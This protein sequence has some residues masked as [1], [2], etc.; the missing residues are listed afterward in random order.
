M[1]W[2]TM[3]QE[4]R[5]SAD[6]AVRRIRDNEWVSL[7]H[8]AGVPQ[9]CVNA[10]I[11]NYK[12]FKNVSIYHMLVL[13]EAKYTEPEMEEA[14]RHVSNFI[15]ANTRSAIKEK[16]V[17]FLPAF[18][19]EIPRMIRERLIPIDV[20]IVQ[21][22]P[23]DEDGNCS[24]GIS[25]DYSKPSTEHARLVIGEINEQMPYIGGDNLIHLSKLDCIVEADYPLY[26]IA[27]PRITEVEEAIGRNCATLIEDGATLQLGIGAIP[28]A[29]LLFLKDKKNLGIHS[30]MF[31]DGV[32]ELVKN[33]VINGKAK[34][35][36]PNK[37]VATFLMGT[38]ALYD[39]VNHNPDVEMYPS[40][41][42]N[43]PRVIAQNDRMISINSCLSVDLAG[44]VSSESIG[45]QQI[46][47]TGGQ[48]DYVRGSNWSKGGKSIMAMPSTAKNGTTSRIVATLTEGTA[49]T[50][51]RN[52]VD[53]VV[54]EYG[55]ARLRGKSLRERAK[56][57]IKIAHPDFREELEAFYQQR[58]H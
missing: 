43:D 28:D 13:G 26:T 21:L 51:S 52:D 9:M 55:V 35:L 54:T 44:Q 5:V 16:R 57:L 20:A 41:Y 19:S 10:L 2:K 7:G 36:H 49:V 58:F 48:V 12:W 50:T 24:F 23:P 31:S 46:S 18:F 56:A 15:G 8:A 25:S 11:R 34:T 37:M 40:D 47:G 39:F 45:L 32:L 42:V 53:Y 38:Q 30:E 6:E 22:S 33:G 14:F 29:V 27:P 4:K 17:D 1:D 3:Y